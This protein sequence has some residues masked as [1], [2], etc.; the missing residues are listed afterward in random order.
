M[1]LKKFDK[2]YKFVSVFNTENGFY[3][4]TGILD[5]K[6]K[7]TGVEVFQSS[8]PELIDIGIM[9]HCVHGESGLCLETGVQC[10]QKGGNTHSENMSLEN[11]IRVIDEIKGKTFQVALGGRGDPNKHENFKEILKYTRINNIIPNYTTSGF[12]LDEKEVELTKKYCGAVAVSWYCKEYTIKAIDMFK[13]AGMKVNIHYVL[14]N[15]SIERALY[16]LNNK[17]F[18]KG[19]NA[20]IFLMHKPVGLGKEDNVLKYEDAVVR[21]FFNIVTS[22]KYPFKIGFDSCSVPALINFNNNFNVCSVDTCEAARW[23][24]YITSDMKALPCS[25]DQKLK[26]SVDLKY[27]SIVNA[28]NS[29]K[30][31]NFRCKLKKTC[32]DC[33]ER[34]NCMGGCPLCRSIILCNRKEV[35]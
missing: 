18:P 5:S 35:Y 21:D 31:E 9:G 3:M 24:M 14:N 4:R 10:Y 16:M 17:G 33:E 13:V 12:L 11:Y 27:K 20:V 7:D 6:G 1:I 26:Y 29:S 8:F 25:F 19:I 2:N 22:K 15:E 34:D 30:F 32:P 28:W 23:S